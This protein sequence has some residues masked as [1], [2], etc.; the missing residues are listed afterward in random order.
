LSFDGEE[1]VG[2]AFAAA[3]NQ[4]KVPLEVI[5]DRRS[6]GPERYEARYVL[7]RPDQFVAWAGDEV[8]P[9]AATLLRRAVGV[10][11]GGTAS[12]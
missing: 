12:G 11:V 4:L 2:G 6:G 8:A 9:D 3:A 1:A 5:G 7:V 10:A